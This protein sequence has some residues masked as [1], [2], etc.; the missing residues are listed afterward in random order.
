M[1]ERNIAAHRLRFTTDIRRAV[2]PSDLI[3]LAMGNLYDPHAMEEPGFE[4]RCVGRR[5]QQ[6]PSPPAGAGPTAVLSLLC[7]R[8]RRDVDIGRQGPVTLGRF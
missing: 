3:F 4:Y 6:V 7:A 1:L 5:V 8:A 2:R